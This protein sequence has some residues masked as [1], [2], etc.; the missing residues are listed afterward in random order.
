MNPHSRP[1]RVCAIIVSYGRDL[2]LKR[3]I[4]SLIESVKICPEIHLQIRVLINGP[5]EGSYRSILELASTLPTGVLLVD[6]VSHAK[7]PAAARN[8]VFNSQDSNESDWIY[9]ID[10]DAYLPSEYFSKFIETVQQYP[11]VAAVGGPNLTPPESSFFQKT[12]GKVLSSPLGTWVSFARY[13]ASGKIRICDDSALILCNLF[14]RSRCL[15]AKA[16]HEELVCSE[17]N[18]LL[19]TLTLQGQTLLYNPS[20]YVW[21][22]RRSSLPQF[23][24]QIYKYGYGRGQTIRRRPWSARYF[25]LTPSFYLICMLFSIR[26]PIF[27]ELGYFYLLTCV[28]WT[29]FALIGS[30]TMNRHLTFLLLTPMLF[31]V[32]HVSYGLGVISGMV[33]PSSPRL[34]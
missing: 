18:W 8:W 13:R 28:V 26:Y 20:L 19:Q 34:E 12:S 6:L 15:S 3:C 16:F 25:H 17:E 31:P 7:T 5:D 30:K 9:F 29:V 32:I 33:K 27:L 11:E 10:D 24:A 23:A 22:E 14:V 1:L 2:W 4:K 21:H